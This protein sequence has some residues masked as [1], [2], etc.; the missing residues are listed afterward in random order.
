MKLDPTIL[1]QLLRTR[2]LS[3]QALSAF[4]DPIL[5]VTMDSRVFFQNRVAQRLLTNLNLRDQLP[6]LLEQLVKPVLATGRNHISTTFV[7]AISVS[8]NDREIFYLPFI[9]ALRDDRGALDGATVILHDLTQLR[10]HLPL[11]RI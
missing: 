6:Y 4:H 7:N 8:V 10:A 9:F 1:P 11:K 5:A 2:E 3:E